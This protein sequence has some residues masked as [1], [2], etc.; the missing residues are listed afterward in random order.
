MDL[1]GWLRSLGLK[2]YE[3][4]FRE[5]AEGPAQSD[6]RGLE[7]IWA[8]ATAVRFSTPSP[9][10][11]LTWTRKCLYRLRKGN[12]ASSGSCGASSWAG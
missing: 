3:A 9:L 1:G 6:G 4:A 7:R 10:C 2:Q 8:S 11:V 12:D 5:N